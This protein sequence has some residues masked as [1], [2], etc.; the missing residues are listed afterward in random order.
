MPD[1]CGRGTLFGLIAV[2]AVVTYLLRVV[3]LVLL[4]RPLRNPYLVALLEYMPFALLSA[5]I[6]PDVYYATDPASA[7]PGA[8]PTPALA[9]AVTAIV[10][11][12]FRLSLPL[13]ACAATIAAFATFLVF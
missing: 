5:M 1:W 10:L 12:F 4:R 8:V 3:P 6:F 7:F 11:A 9:G 2:T 13:V